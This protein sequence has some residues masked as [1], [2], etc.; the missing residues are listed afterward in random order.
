MGMITITE[1]ASRVGISRRTAD[2]LIARGEFIPLYQLPT[3]SL[4]CSEFDLAEW[5]DACKLTGKQI[6]EEE[7]TDGN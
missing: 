3:G 7:E 4:R 1:A 5:L 6:T 2:R